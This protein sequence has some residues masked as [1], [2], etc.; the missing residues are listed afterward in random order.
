MSSEETTLLDWWRILIG[1]VPASFMIE[2]VVRIIILY[3]LLIFSL[4]IMGKRMSSLVSRN[5]MIAMISL[6]AAIGIPVQDP[7]SGL[8]PAVIIAIVVILVQRFISNRTMYDTTFAHMVVGNVGPLVKDGQLV[9]DNM[10]RSRISRERLLTQVR[11]EEIYNLGRVERVFLEANGNFTFY[12]YSE[13][14]VGLCI[15]PDWDEEFI[16]EMRKAQDEY[17]CGT[18]GTL[19]QEQNK[20]QVKCSHCGYANWQNAIIS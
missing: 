13:E 12:M 3:L 14:R 16:A 11:G 17:T 5:E 15:L 6:A 8:L 1:E 18:C 9:L 20:P 10:Q 2:V 4:R 7:G 19:V